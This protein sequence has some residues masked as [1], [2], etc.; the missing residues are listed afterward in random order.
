[1][2]LG[3]GRARGSCR[4]RSREIL[5]LSA[6]PGRRPLQTRGDR[7]P[8]PEMET[9]QPE[10][11][12]AAAPRA[13]GQQHRGHWWPPSAQPLAACLAPAASFV[14]S[15]PRLPP[16]LLLKPSGC[17]GPRQSPGPGPGSGCSAQLGAGLCLAASGV[18]K[19]CLQSHL[20]APCVQVREHGRGV[21]AGPGLSRAG[22]C[23]LPPR[24][25]RTRIPRVADGPAAGGSFPAINRF[26]GR[27]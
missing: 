27:K 22:L 9:P 20:D 12:P 3:Q 21:G 26:L 4:A 2:L 19:P 14:S 11:R 6:L 25:K 10:P 23:L 15:T 16:S 7:H 13:R 18:R 1:M 5:I 17:A 8:N 24:A